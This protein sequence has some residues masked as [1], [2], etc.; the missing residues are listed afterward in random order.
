MHT[1]RRHRAGEACSGWRCCIVGALLTA[2][3]GC[4][5][6]ARSRS[7]AC[8]PASLDDIVSVVLR[9]EGYGSGRF[10]LKDVREGSKRHF[11]AVYAFPAQAPVELAHWMLE[12]STAPA[13]GLID[14]AA[15]ASAAD[16]TV[17]A[18][19]GSRYMAVDRINVRTSY[20]PPGLFTG[21]AFTTRDGRFDIQ[22][23]ASNLLPD[24]VAAP[25]FDANELGARMLARYEAACDDG[26]DG[27]RR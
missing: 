10:H 1:E 22:I 7:Q 16:P 20:A 11:L 5:V 25:R 19:L 23:T 13:G 8:S 18:P 4:A 12:V 6:G 17:Q 26:R 27:A 14:E 15:Y 9:E 24:R 2:A 3:A 21:I